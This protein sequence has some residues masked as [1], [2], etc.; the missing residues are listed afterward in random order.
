M[1]TEDEKGRIPEPGEPARMPGES[2]EA[3]PE[4]DGGGENFG[5]D[6]SPPEVGVPGEV[7]EEIPGK[8]S[9]EEVQAARTLEEFL[10]KLSEA[11]ERAE[12]MERERE[13]FRAELARARADF[14]NYR[15]RVERDRERDRKLAAERAVEAL[16]PVLDNLDRTL[17]ASADP[18]DPFTRGVEMVRRQFLQALKSLGLEEVSSCGCP[19]DPARHEAFGTVA[20]EDPALDGTV[21]E[22]LER[23]WVLAGKVLKA[24]RVRVGRAC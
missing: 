12:A 20:V 14:V 17:A 19:F 5:G 4:R 15:N 10:A 8:L 18:E 3:V 13:E 22:E 11:E 2:P 24:S 1:T 6:A 23:G 16:F 7:P 21:V 9:P